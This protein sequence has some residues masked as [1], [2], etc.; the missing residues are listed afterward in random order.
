MEVDTGAAASLISEAMY[1]GSLARLVKPP[2]KCADVSLHTYSGEVL[3]VVGQISVTVK[4]QDQKQQL[5]LLVHRGLTNNGRIFSKLDLS[6]AFQ[7][8]ELDNDSKRFVTISTQRGLYQYNRLPFGVSSAPAI[9]Q[10]TMEML[11]RDIPNVCVYIDDVLVSG[12]SE[13]EHLKTLESVLDKLQ[14]SGLRLK[15]S[16]CVFMVSFVEYLG[17]VI[18]ADGVRPTE[19]KRR[20]IVNAPTPQDVGQLQSFCSRSKDPGAGAGPN[21]R[22]S[23]KQNSYLDV[24][25]HF[26]PQK[27]LL[28]LCDASPYGVKAVLSHETEDGSDRPIAYALHLVPSQEKVD[29]AIK[30]AISANDNRYH[31]V[32]SGLQETESPSLDI[33]HTKEIVSSLD[34]GDDVIFVD[35]YRLGK[36]APDGN[37]PRLLKVRFASSLHRSLVLRKAKSLKNSPKYSKVYIRPC[38]SPAER[39]HISELYSALHDLK[40][41]TGKDHYIDRR[42]PIK[43]W[44]VKMRIEKELSSATVDSS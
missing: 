28:L 44:S 31:V 16:K 32:I 22:R 25:T 10:R 8:L 23:Y 18:S 14:W 19:E 4:F 38:H 39:K 5:P 3:P 15:M 17:H 43:E 35:A 36:R 29:I 12:T 2:L 30:E 26:D 42:G 6:N 7:Q 9:F 20:A 24:L 34:I 40:Q 37:R 13:G 33:K 21:S 27:K 1:K 11:L 41:K